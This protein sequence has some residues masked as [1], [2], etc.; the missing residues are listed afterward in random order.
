VRHGD[1]SPVADLCLKKG[2]KMKISPKL[3]IILAVLF[4]SGNFFLGKIAVQVIPPMTLAFLRW[5]LAFLL[6][7]PFCSK[8]IRA[9]HQEIK[10]NRQLFLVLGIT[11]IMGFNVFVY[12]AVKYTTAINA[13]IINA[14]T[15]MLTAIL[16][17]F[18]LKERLSLKQRG[19]GFYR[20]F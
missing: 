12:L 15:P 5:F 1:D 13:T 20:P 11:G 4:W 10:E 8:E 7:L 16:A 17:V 9:K 3:L 6:F 2:A 14:S 19:W 18:F